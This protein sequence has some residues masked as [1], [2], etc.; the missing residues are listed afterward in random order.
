MAIRREKVQF[1][2]KLGALRIEKKSVEFKME[3]EERKVCGEKRKIRQEKC[4]TEK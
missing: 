1:V 3:K 2:C 4:T